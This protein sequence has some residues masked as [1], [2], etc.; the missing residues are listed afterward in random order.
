MTKIIEP[1]DREQTFCTLLTTSSQYNLLLLR[2]RVK[3]LPPATKLGQG[4]IFRS[5]CQEFCP[6]WGKVWQGL[7]AWQ[8]GM[9]GRGHAWQGGHVWQWGHAWQGRCVWQ[10]GMHG[11]GHAW[12]GGGHTWHTVNEQAVGSLLEC[13]LVKCCMYVFQMLYFSIGLEK[14]C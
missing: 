10:G 4:N 3:L 12:Q 5:M 11:R 7:C 9:H 14:A 8:G 6:Q 13:I 2:N 1:N